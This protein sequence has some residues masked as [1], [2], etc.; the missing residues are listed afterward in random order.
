MSD[1]ATKIVATLGFASDSPEKIAALVD[2]GVNVFRLNFSH[3]TQAEHAQRIATIR[4]VEAKAGRAIA[5]LA[6][7]QGPKYRIGE[8][9]DGVVLEAGQEL[10]LDMNAE[11]G[12][13]SRVY[14]PHPEIF[15]ALLPG[16]HL[17]LDDGK[18]RLIVRKMETEALVTEVVVG[19]PLSSRKGV[20]IPDVKLATSPLTKKD[21]SDLAFALD[22]GVDWIALSFVQSVGDVLDARTLIGERALLMAKIEKPA[23]LDDIDNIIQAS[24]G[25]MVA[26]GDLGVEL[27]PEKVPSVQKNLVGKC[28]QIGKPVLVATQML[29]SMILAP[30]PTRAEASDVATAVFDGADGVMLSAETAAGQYPVEAVDIMVR[31]IQSAE[32]HIRSFPHDGPK[33]MPIEHTVYHAVAHAAVALADAVDAKALVA[34]TA[35]GNTA[36]RIARERPNTQLIAFT[37]S[38]D[39]ARRLAILW[40]VHCFMQAE[41]E[42]EEAVSEAKQRLQASRRIAMGETMVVVAGMPFGLAGS[43]NSMRVVQ[44]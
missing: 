6:D 11:T 28:R 37:P 13:G 14:L 40:G 33:R 22:Q 1:R 34:F 41:T 43:T 18:L 9:K 15:D 27:P 4:E 24:D 31:I 23:A 3:G 25:I 35:S 19:G 12:D 26:R 10:R 29:E 2:A 44:I 20:N 17:L 38:V 30:T 7:M 36:V 42:Y 8:V 16:H 39:V 5:I 21:R 32:Q